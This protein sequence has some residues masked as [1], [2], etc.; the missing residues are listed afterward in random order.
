MALTSFPTIHALL[1]L[2]LHAGLGYTYELEGS[3]TS[4]A[5]YPKWNP[6]HNGSLSFE[7]KTDQPNGLLLYADDGGRYDF[8]EV[9]IVGGVIRLRWNLGNGAVILTLGQNLNDEEWHKVQIERNIQET[10]L[11]VDQI[12]QSR[13]TNGNDI[14]FGNL[15]TNS[16]VFI[17]GL[18]I[19]FSAK[20][21]EL[22][23]P[24]VMFEP[25][26]MGAIRNVLYSNCSQLPV[27][28]DMIDWS[29][30]RSSTKDACE[31]KNP[32]L[33]KGTCISTDSGAIC[34]CTRTNYEGQHCEIGELRFV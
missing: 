17:G 5:K 3:Q 32:C 7:F 12:T 11:T 15:S 25:R 18:P 22:A 6:C 28:V 24:S 29:G 19:G 13:A 2:L 10:T 21:S 33:N 9:K 27:R 31:E 26:Y 16:Y 30:I 1:L 34:D 8:F 20:L 14:E 23:L 4:Y